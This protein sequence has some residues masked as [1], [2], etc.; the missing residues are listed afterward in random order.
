MKLEEASVIAAL[1]PHSAER[2]CLS[3]TVKSFS[4]L[5]LGRWRHSLQSKIQLAGKA[6]PFRTVR[7]QSRSVLVNP[8]LFPVDSSAGAIALGSEQKT[9]PLE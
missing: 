7:R 9:A 5:R 6:K 2:L 4:R 8:S 1:P 3:G